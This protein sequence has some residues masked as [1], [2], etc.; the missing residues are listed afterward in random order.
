MKKLLAIFLSAILLLGIFAGCS[1]QTD[2]PIS[3]ENTVPTPIAAG[4][5]VL[6][7]G[8]SVN[9]SYDSDGLVLNVE[10]ADESG[11]VVVGEYLDYLGKATS[12]AVCDLIGLCGLSGYLNAEN[13]FVLIKQAMGSALP[14]DTF[15]ETI[16]TDAESAVKEYS[17]ARVLLFT[18]E[19]LDK[20]GYINLESAE[21][22]LLAH[23]V[24]DSFDTLA[25]STEPVEGLYGFAVTASDMEARFIVDAVTGAVCEGELDDVDYGDESLDEELGMADPADESIADET[26]DSS[27]DPEVS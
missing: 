19:N 14:S 18:E 6:N 22:L 7:A 20:D 5:L 24:L 8:A 11:S 10:G 4:M 17:P 27:E 2:D 16:A 13:G 1:N 23:L 21:Q 12:D 3:T 15:L 26:V 9:I 25:G